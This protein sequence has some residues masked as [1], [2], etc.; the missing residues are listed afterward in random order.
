LTRAVFRAT[1]KCATDGYILTNY[2]AVGQADEIDV[3]LMDKREFTA[4]VVGTD[5]KTDL[6]LI[7]IN[8][9]E[10]LPFATLGDSRQVQ[11]GAWVLA[12]GNPFG[13]NLTATNGIVSATGRALGGNYDTFIQ[14]DASINP[15]NSGGPCSILAGK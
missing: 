15:G 9:D 8:T 6:A 12:I 4:K 3:T 11:V 14:T 1:Q 7:K 5:R 13:F 10:P 2:H